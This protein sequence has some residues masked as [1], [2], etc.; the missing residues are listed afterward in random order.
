MKSWDRAIAD[1]EEAGRRDPALKTQ[2]TPALAAAYS[3][4][5]ADEQER[6]EHAEADEQIRRQQ[7][8]ADAAIR[9]DN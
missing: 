2:L 3:D 8:A 7:A 9:G 6:R 1:L 4:R 5:A